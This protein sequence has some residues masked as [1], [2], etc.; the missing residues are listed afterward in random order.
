MV[1]TTEDF[2][3]H[4]RNN[5]RETVGYGKSVNVTPLHDDRMNSQLETFKG[6]N[7]KPGINMKT[8]FECT[9]CHREWSS[10]YGNTQW[11][12]KLEILRSGEKI[13]GCKL[14]FKVHT[15]TQKCERCNGQGKINA[16]DDED[17]RLSQI[18]CNKLAVQMGLPEKFKIKAQRP[19][20]GMRRGHQRSRCGACKA[21]V[22][23]SRSKGSVLF[24]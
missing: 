23:N 12:Y 7:G 10:M 11:Y 4:V 24:I 13:T 15:Y 22:C 3:Q 1:N 6:K 14:F 8:K 5:L 17:E 20:P 19:S 9:T 16:Y 2:V 18:L 21:G